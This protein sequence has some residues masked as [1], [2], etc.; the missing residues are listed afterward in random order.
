MIDA[1]GWQVFW[2]IRVKDVCHMETAR[3]RQVEVFAEQRYPYEIVWHRYHKNQEV[4]SLANGS[5][6]NCQSSGFLIHQH[7]FWIR[8]TQSEPA[9]KKHTTLI[10]GASWYSWLNGVQ[11][12]HLSNPCDKTKTRDDGVDRGQK[13]D[14]FV[15]LVRCSFWCHVLIV[16]W[17]K[18][19]I[20]SARLCSFSWRVFGVWVYLAFV[21]FCY[22][23]CC[24]YKHG[25]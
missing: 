23:K 2:C 21:L 11:R 12:F 6:K 25:T 5:Q 3:V 15:W 8:S 16:S 13:E 1:G 14:G 7:F 19:E 20:A 18:Y 24:T 22:F 9:P 17:R 4:F 10:W